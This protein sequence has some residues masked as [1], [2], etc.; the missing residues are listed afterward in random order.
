MTKPFRV[1]QIDHVEL[2]VPD[3]YEAARWYERVLGLEILPEYE[4]WATE[5]GPLMIS[6]DG[7]G[8]MLALFERS[9]H[10]AAETFRCR[11]VAF[12]VA[13]SGFMQFLARLDEL[14]LLND[15]GEPL[16]AGQVV[17]HDKAY[18][19][20]F[21]DPYGQPYEVTTYDYEY[22]SSHLANVKRKT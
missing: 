9:G 6:S 17:D 10:R 2:L 11:R 16:T 7:G 15:G 8:T 4:H 12:R 1:Q 3:R 22:V 5:G 21:Q 19:I 20:Y 18:S 13:G 14:S